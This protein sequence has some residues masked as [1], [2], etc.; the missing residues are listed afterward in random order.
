MSSWPGVDLVLGE[1][2]K[3]RSALTCV[4]YNLVE[5]RVFVEI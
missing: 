2:G 3:G 5:T 1:L 4:D